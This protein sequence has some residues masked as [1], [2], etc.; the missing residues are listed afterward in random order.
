MSALAM[1]GLYAMVKLGAV[2]L[3]GNLGTTFRSGFGAIEGQVVDAEGDPVSGATVYASNVG[4]LSG[5]QPTTYTSEKGGFFL[6]SVPV[7]RNIVHASKES[8]GYPNTY[9]AFFAA[10][11]GTVPEV[12]VY[13]KKVT[14]GVVVRLGPR[15][16]TLEGQILDAETRRPVLNATILLTRA[17]N[18]RIFISR[19]PE[20]PDARFHVLVPPVGFRMQV[21]AAGYEDWHYAKD[22]SKHQLVRLASNETRNVIILL[23][24]INKHVR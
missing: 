16:G 2:V 22:S 15:A 5:R 18:P 8:Q 19:G 12:R 11:A 6:E 9:F 4:H 3:P 21:S 1:I 17:D 13:D 14:R 24:P 20:Y 7:G 23:H 10:D